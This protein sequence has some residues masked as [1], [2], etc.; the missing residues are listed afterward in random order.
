MLN[1]VLEVCIMENK[2]IKNASSVSWE[3]KWS[4]F[5]LAEQAIPNMRL[6]CFAKSMIKIQEYFL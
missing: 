1:L 2:I 5:I 3:E 6:N 4:E